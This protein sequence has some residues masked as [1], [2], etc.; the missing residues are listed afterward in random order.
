MDKKEDYAPFI[1]MEVG[2]ISR[3][4]NLRYWLEDIPHNIKVGVRN[5]CRKLFWPKC[6][7]CGKTAYF[8]HYGGIANCERCKY[9]FTEEEYGWIYVCWDCSFEHE[10]H[11]NVE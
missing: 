7:I 10:G 8:E 9:Y 2:E 4:D 11:G 5:I 3:V 6:D 1:P